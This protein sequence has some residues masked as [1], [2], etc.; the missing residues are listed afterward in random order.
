MICVR[1]IW[2]EYSKVQPKVFLEKPGIEPGT[3]GLQG[4][5]LIH[6]NTAASRHRLSETPVLAGRTYGF[7][8]LCPRA[9]EDSTGSGSGSLKRQTGRSRESNMRPLV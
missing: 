6:Y 5:A 2:R 4:I 1:I 9:L 3:P 7:V 8:V